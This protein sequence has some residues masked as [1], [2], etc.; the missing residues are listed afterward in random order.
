M[1]R[2]KDFQSFNTKNGVQVL[3]ENGDVATIRDE[4]AGW[5]IRITQPDGTQ[6]LHEWQR[7]KHVVTC[8]I[9]VYPD[10]DI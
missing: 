9:Y 2:Q 5:A 4:P 8:L 6:F 7:S 10:T 3:M 1:I